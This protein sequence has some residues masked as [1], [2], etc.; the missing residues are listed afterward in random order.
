MLHIHQKKA[1][2]TRMKKRL[3]D[4]LKPLKA[5]VFIGLVDGPLELGD[6]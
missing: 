2:M 4:N 6:Q 1:L 3:R 5:P